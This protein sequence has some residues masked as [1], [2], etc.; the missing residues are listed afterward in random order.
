[1]IHLSGLSC[2]RGGREVLRALDLAVA[3][4]ELLVVLGP[5]GSGKTTLL[6][7]VAG[8]ERPSAGEIRLGD[9]VASTPTT[10]LAPERRRIG[11]VF[12]D[13]ALW[14]HLTA[15]EHVEFAL[16]GA[17]VPRAARRARAAALLADVGLAACIGK[18]PD[19]LSGGERQRLA[20]ARAV[21][22]APRVLLLDE[23]FSAVEPSLRAELG[24]WVRALH[25]R[26]GATSLFVTHRV[27]EGM[28]LA[29]RVAVLRAGRLVQVGTPD[30]L[31]AAPRSAFV[32]ELM[33]YANLLPV[34]AFA[35]A[36]AVDT[37][38]G[39]LTVAA[40]GCATHDGAWCAALR[41][42]QVCSAP[43]G[44]AATPAA[45]AGVDGAVSCRVGE[46]LWH[47][48][49]LLYRGEVAGA[50]VLFR[51]DAPLSPGATVALRITAA[52]RLVRED[53]DDP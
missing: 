5:S 53:R 8:L 36:D 1:M 39:R 4:G 31:L 10:L 30:E 49:R 51:A 15:V 6:R 35:A 48:E 16:R 13:L 34:R 28:A 11:M 44:A 3:P 41:A 50:S 21:A 43:P 24:A 26:L 20:V 17:A 18:P 33:G 46:R 32:A 14:P 25:R 52:A 22:G 47:P 45:G 38:L 27:E 42:D 9:A 40:N 7:L 2:S 19:L 12:Q 23:P 29:D 37:P